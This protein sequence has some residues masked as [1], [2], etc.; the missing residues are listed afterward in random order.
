LFFKHRLYIG[1]EKAPQRKEMAGRKNS[2]FWVRSWADEGCGADM[3][4]FGP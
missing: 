3:I 1:G 2:S 4:E